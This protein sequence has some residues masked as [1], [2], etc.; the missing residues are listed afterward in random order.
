MKTIAYISGTRADFG[1][2][3]PVLRAINQHPKLRLKLYA[4]GIHLMPEFG[5]TINEVRRHF[6]EV[7]P[8][9]ATIDSDERHG[10]PHFIAQLSTKLTNALRNDRPDMVLLLGDRA[11]QLTAATVCL[12]LGIPTAHLH[13][14]EKTTTVDD[15]ARHAITS[16][17]SW[18]FPATKESAQR[19]Q[20]MGVSKA[21]IH[22]VGAPA[23]DILKNTPLP[24]RAIKENFILLTL[25]PISEAVAQA[26]KHMKTV[27]L[28]LLSFRMP[29]IAIYPHADA[30]GRA[31]I[32][33]LE[34]ER[35]NPL[36][37]IIPSLPYE[38][39]LAMERDA[40]V[41]VGNSSAMM[42]ESPFF[43][44]PVVNVGTRQK[45]RQRG[46]NVID[47]DYNA[48]AIKRAVAAALNIK[49]R[50]S[51]NPW[52]DGRASQHIVTFL[53]KQIAY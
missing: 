39:F 43:G 7:V 15:A 9:R 4:T 1:L 10:T 29:I 2:M 13:G 12:Y 48:Q 40:S 42:I 5:A 26:R 18:H 27:L 51:K 25:H 33:V 22:I 14:G 21:R 16:L 35:K 45:G 19:I 20:S 31:M 30:G 11:E 32:S 28:A 34:Q 47:V 46:N 50:Q 17:A 37:K 23:L 38:E 41:W 53:Q 8:L 24:P 3:S 52:G 49:R 44:T 36:V 6:P